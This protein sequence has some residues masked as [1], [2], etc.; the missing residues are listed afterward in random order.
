MLGVLGIIGAGITAVY[1]IKLLVK[2]FF[3]PLDEKWQNQTD[4]T[5]L[6]GFSAAVLVG[7]VL[8]VGLFPFP[9]IRVI[10]T[11]V[12]EILSRFPGTG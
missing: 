5:K 9:F 7:F 3:G 8:L 10:N 2:V 6:E 4:A 11:G 1:I 12:A